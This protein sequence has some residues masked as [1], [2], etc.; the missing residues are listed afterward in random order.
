MAS[1]DFVGVDAAAAAATAALDR[2]DQMADIVG[3]VG[4]EVPEASRISFETATDGLGVVVG[5]FDQQ[6]DHAVRLV[7]AE[8]A[9]GGGE[10]LLADVGLIGEDPDADLERIHALW[11]EGDT[12]A[13]AEAADDLVELLDAA[14]GRGTVRLIVPAAFIA[15]VV[16]GY[17]GVRRRVRARLDGQPTDAS[18]APDDD[19]VEL[20]PEL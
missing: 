11:R 6:I 17:L 10:G 18:A 8:R 2:R 9:A 20:T 4:L 7:A 3:T 5:Q 15:F 12:R 19:E 13:A 16:A 1:W 14:P